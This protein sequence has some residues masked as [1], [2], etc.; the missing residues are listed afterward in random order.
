MANIPPVVGA[1][2]EIPKIVVVVERRPDIVVVPMTRGAAGPPGP[3]GPPGPSG[4]GNRRWYGE[5]PPTVVP[6]SSAGDE[7]VDTNTMDTY[8]L[9]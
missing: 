5:G 8:I 6:G 3:P 1:V 7:Y 9:R 4:S 2:E